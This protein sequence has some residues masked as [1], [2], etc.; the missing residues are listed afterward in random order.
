MLA[1]A[2]D[3]EGVVRYPL[4]A[5]SVPVSAY[6]PLETTGD[7]WRPLESARHWFLVLAEAALRTLGLHWPHSLAS[8]PPPHRRHTGLGAVEPLVV[9]IRR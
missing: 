6:R 1:P 2:G 7:H 9:I 5:H 4:A 3:A 8:C